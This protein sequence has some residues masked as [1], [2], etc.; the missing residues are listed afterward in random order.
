MLS[1]FNHACKS[2]P[3]FPKSYLGYAAQA[4]YGGRVEARIVKM[5]LQCVYL[6]FLSMYPTGLCTPGLMVEAHYTGVA[7]SRR[8]SA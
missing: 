3:D 6:D 5:L 7:R 4:Y 1:A 8:G 2:S